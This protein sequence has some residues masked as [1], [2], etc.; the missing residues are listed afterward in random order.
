MAKPLLRAAADSTWEGS[1]A[2]EE[3][4]EPICFTTGDFGRS[5]QSMLRRD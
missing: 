3:F 5:V 1:L 2:M 4:A